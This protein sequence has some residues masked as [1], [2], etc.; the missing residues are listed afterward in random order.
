MCVSLFLTDDEI[1]L[2]IF[3]LLLLWPCVWAHT[4]V[5]TS[6]NT[7]MTNDDICKSWNSLD[8]RTKGAFASVF[9]YA[10]WPIHTTHTTHHHIRT[11]YI[12]VSTAIN[13][14]NTRFMCFLVCFCIGMK[15]MFNEISQFAA[16]GGGRANWQ[17][18][19]RIGVWSFSFREYVM[20]LFYWSWPRTLRTN[21][22]SVIMKE[23]PIL[24]LLWLIWKIMKFYISRLI[25][26]H[27][28]EYMVFAQYPHNSNKRKERVDW[29]WH[30]T[31]SALHAHTHIG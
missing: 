12:R 3:F 4:R 8:A 17:L 2:I 26:A 11:I 6:Y 16:Y 31:F 23:F 14:R 7:I 9:S 27:I 15:R 18:S 30:L 25:G 13:T 28:Y 10:D 22:I 24:L 20:F 21:I 19:N 29:V 5:G 1:L